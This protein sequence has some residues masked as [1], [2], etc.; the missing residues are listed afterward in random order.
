MFEMIDSLLKTGTL[1][2]WTHLQSLNIVKS[3]IYTILNLKKKGDYSYS[4]YYKFNYVAYFGAGKKT[5]H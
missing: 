4:N 2:P 3:K 5:S 1:S